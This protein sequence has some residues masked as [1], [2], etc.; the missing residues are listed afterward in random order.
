[1]NFWDLLFEDWSMSFYSEPFMLLCNISAVIFLITRK[2]T[3]NTFLFFSSFAIV[4]LFATK[5]IDILE[6]FSY[7]NRRLIIEIT[8]TTYEFVELYIFQ[9]YYSK[10]LAL[11]SAKY[12]NFTIL[13]FGT[14][15][16]LF[17]LFISIGNQKNEIIFEFSYLINVI[18]LLILLITSLRYFVFLIKNN[19]NDNPLEDPLFW[20]STGLLFYCVASIP[21]F[22]LAKA[23]F[24]SSFTTFSF[25]FGLHFIT[26]GLLFIFII[27]ASLCKKQ[28]LK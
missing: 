16:L 3:T 28:H 13:S 23:L 15:A 9:Y 2:T 5:V 14:I 27:R 19:Q 6:I 22:M 25:F 7:R 11:F 18:E 10:N 17:V 21:F 20:I 12:R 26:F 1:M 24:Y 8:N 4:C